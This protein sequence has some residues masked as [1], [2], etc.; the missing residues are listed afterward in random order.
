LLPGPQV[1]VRS[2]ND[3]G[4]ESERRWPR[5]PAPHLPVIGTVGAN[6]NAR[7]EAG[8]RDVAQPTRRICGSL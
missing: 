5:V 8:T 4:G 7:A 3:A 2:A 1:T 6:S